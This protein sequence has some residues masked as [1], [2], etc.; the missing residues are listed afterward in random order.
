MDDH[1]EKRPSGN[2]LRRNLKKVG[3]YGGFRSSQYITE[4]FGV[5]G[6]RPVLYASEE[7]K[8]ISPD[9]KGW[10]EAYE[11]SVQGWS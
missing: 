3:Y 10:G 9:G 11:D 4:S 7:M 2:A 1:N 8:G 6:G 5:G